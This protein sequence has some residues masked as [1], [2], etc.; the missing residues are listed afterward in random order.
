MIGARMAE[1]AYLGILGTEAL[2]AMGFAFPISMFL[3]AFASGIGT[4][5]SSVIARVYGAGDRAQAARLVTHAQLLVF[6]VS[7]AI[8]AFGLVFAQDLLSLLGAAGRS[9]DHGHRVPAHL[10]AGFPA[11]HAV[12]GGLDSA[13]RHGQR[14]R[15]PA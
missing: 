9:P 11:V 2:A 4:G 7:V 10:H 5:A 1:A 6:L 15:V 8:S 3:F 14:R 12:D 13:T